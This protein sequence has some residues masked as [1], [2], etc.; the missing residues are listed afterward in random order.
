M[1]IRATY[2]KTETV[3]STRFRS[4]ARTRR[5]TSTIF[6]KRETFS[7]IV[8]NKPEDV[9]ENN[10]QTPPVPRFSIMDRRISEEVIQR[11]DSTHP[12][13]LPV[14]EIDTV[15][16][17]T[18]LNNSYSPSDDGFV[19]LDFE[20][21]EAPPQ[22]KSYH[23]LGLNL[24]IP[25]YSATR[26][27]TKESQGMGFEQRKAGDY[28]VW[29]VNA[30]YEEDIP[31]ISIID[32]DDAKIR[33]I[34]EISA[35]ENLGDIRYSNNIIDQDYSARSTAELHPFTYDQKDCVVSQTQLAGNDLN[36]NDNTD[37]EV[38]KS[39]QAEVQKS[40][41]FNPFVGIVVPG[42]FHES[43]DYE[44]ADVD[45]PSFLNFALPNDIVENLDTLGINTES[46]KNNSTPEF[47]EHEES[48][49]WEDVYIDP[50]KLCP[51]RPSDEKTIFVD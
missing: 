17:L 27:A 31:K 37:F 30:A 11:N 38:P 18:I 36:N 19:S 48:D 28:D 46:F 3:V 24:E 40:K 5:P 49:D 16:S 1:L 47:T 6:G 20:Y 2:K 41:A 29:S 4:E 13:S 7:T 26:R 39:G 22:E 50:K 43:N 34:P 12:T 44:K 8:D 35:I 21:D 51:N 25:S 45:S 10:D 42:D 33:T 32:F 15:N 14:D 23:S 9:N